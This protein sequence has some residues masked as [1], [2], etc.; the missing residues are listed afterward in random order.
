MFSRFK[1]KSIGLRISIAFYLLILCLI[2]L[3][4]TIIG[5]MNSIE[6]NTNDI[7]R[8]WMPSI[9]EI[10]RLNYTTEHILSL[11]YRYFDADAS[12]RPSINE[13]R[14]KF[15]RETA[16]AMAAYDKLSKSAKEAENWNSFKDKWEAYLK[17]N[18]QAIRLSDEGQTQLAKEV[19]VK[20]ADSFDTMQVNLDYLV[21][22]NQ[23]QSDASAA[24]TIR[25]VQDG[26]LA[27][28]I[29]VLVMI[30]ITAIFVPIIRTQVVKPL[31]RVI[32]AVKLIAEGQLNVQD[33]HTKHED[34]VGALAKAVNEMKAN[35]TSMVLNV[36]RVA[37][38]VNRQSNELAIASEEVKIGSQ[39]I[40]ITMEE[41]AKAAESQAQTAVESAR[42]VEELNDHIQK[43][44]EQGNQLRNMS[45]QVLEQ[46]QNGRK[47]MEESVQQMQQIASVV[48]SSMSKM[49]Q[50][51]RKNEDIS[52]LVLVIHDIARQTNLLALNASI[53]AARAGESG[54]GFAVV[55]SEVRKLSEAVQASVEEITTITQDIQQDS[56][57][58]VN[59]LRVGVQ[60]TQLGQEHVLASGQLFGTI[61][62]SVEGMVE[63]IGIMTDGLAGMEESSGQM[64][65][66]SQQISAVSEQSAA[67]VEEVSAS[68]EEQVSSLEMISSNIQT[69]KE[70]SD[71]LVVSIE[72]LKV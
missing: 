25:S 41:S 46:G 47:A 11:S 15:I 49:E 54:R 66:F 43:H 68:A 40:A 3:S 53:E 61:N 38:T 51:N 39:Q 19:A 29:G 2:I 9:Q 34:E 18:T 10:N 14:T 4:V 71:E 67:S 36:R 72:K 31:L 6:T 48:S 59:E 55:A 32:S 50:L 33:V 17:I 22:Y 26:R 12:D 23:Q 70:M 45:N 16:Q 1:I 69:L 57:G 65:D 44:A 64:N 37:E 52:K 8:N 58:V 27:V 62:Q 28:I 35:L 13:E 20:G 63:V 24:Q 56:Q 42:A 7:T 60:E 21:N 30:I 5:R